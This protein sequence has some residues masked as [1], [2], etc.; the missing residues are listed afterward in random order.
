MWQLTSPEGKDGSA[1]QTQSRDPE[2]VKRAIMRGKQKARQ[3]QSGSQ[4]SVAP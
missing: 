3:S 4:L 1:S 2:S